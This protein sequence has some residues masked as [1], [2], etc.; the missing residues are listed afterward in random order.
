MRS[1]SQVQQPYFILVVAHSLHGR[2]R[3]IHVPYSVLYGILIFALV[4]AV[5]L[6]GAAASYARMFWKVSNY[7]SLR[8]E[9]ETVRSRYLRLE[10]EHTEGKKQMATLQVLASE[11]STAYGIKRSAEPPVLQ[12]ASASTPSKGSL[13]VPTLHETID[14]YNFLRNTTLPSS[15]SRLLDRSSPIRPRLSAEDRPS[16]WPVQGRLTS[17]FGQRLDPFHGHGSFHS[18]IDIS[19]PIGT[20]IVAT[21][22]GLVRLAERH[23][24]YGNLVVLDHGNGIETYYAHLS[25][26][27]VFPGQRIARGEVLGLSGMTGR[28]T[29][30]H[31]HYE[32]RIG[33]TPVNPYPYLKNY[34]VMTARSGQAASRSKDLPF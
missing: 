2:L 27:R 6:A 33:G 10:K 29:S 18:G 8:A 11:I 25:I 34:S 15:S 5:T 26:Y 20:P 31:L 28:A 7:N 30:P 21:S 23:S 4:G 1:V 16:L 17:F 12:N 14:T 22:G 19:V 32:V 13:L 24:G 3:R 9:I